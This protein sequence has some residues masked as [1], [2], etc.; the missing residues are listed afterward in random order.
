[1]ALIWRMPAGMEYSLGLNEV[2][3]AKG[4]F[5]GFWQS[6][7]GEDAAAAGLAAAAAAGAAGLAAGKGISYLPS[8]FN[9]TCRVLRL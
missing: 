4:S 6:I 7:K 1:M 9:N 3:G 5:P 8:Y 2:R